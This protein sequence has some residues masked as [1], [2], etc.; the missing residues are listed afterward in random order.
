MSLQIHA[1]TSAHAQARK[2]PDLCSSRL[3]GA[4]SDR[5]GRPAATLTSADAL[6]GPT[7]RPAI[8]RVLRQMQATLET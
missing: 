3:T 8:E 7:A 2:V 6:P 1:G 4:A 5:A